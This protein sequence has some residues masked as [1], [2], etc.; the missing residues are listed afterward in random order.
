MNGTVSAL[1]SRLHK[2]PS[3]APTP[4]NAA[5]SNNPAPVHKASFMTW[6]LHDAVHVA[7]HHWIPCFFAMGLLF[8]MG[9]EYTLRMVPYIGFVTTHW[10]HLLLASSPNL[11]ILLAGFNTFGNVVGFGCI[12]IWVSLRC[13]S[14]ALGFFF[15]FKFGG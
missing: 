6:T 8:F 2:R 4:A 13:L 11:N 7:R 10:L 15:C 12:C 14:G 5:M 3:P 1:T 9:V